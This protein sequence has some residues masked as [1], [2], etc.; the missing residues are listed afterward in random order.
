VGPCVSAKHT[1]QYG[2]DIPERA[3][4]VA[5][6]GALCVHDPVPRLNGII[7]DALIAKNGQSYRERCIYYSRPENAAER[8][9]IVEK[10]R[11][12]VL[13]NHT[14][15]HRLS[16]LFGALGWGGEAAKMLE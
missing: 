14:Y 8:I 15:H 6:C 2:I 1:Q 16:G 12:H 3:F 13:N 5:L 4:K 7:P 11:Q 9:E 10:Q